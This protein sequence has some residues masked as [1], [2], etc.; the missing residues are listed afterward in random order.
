MNTRS[1]QCFL[2]VDQ[3]IKN[4][5]CL[6]NQPLAEKLGL[7][8][9][10]LNKIHLLQ[11]ATKNNQKS[12]F[13]ILATILNGEFNKSED[14]HLLL[15]S[16]F[17]G[18]LKE[19]LRSGSLSTLDVQDES[20]LK[21][22]FV[23]SV[24][25]AFSGPLYNLKNAQTNLFLQKY[26]LLVESLKRQF[27]TYL[28]LVPT[29]NSLYRV[30][31]ENI[32]LHKTLVFMINNKYYLFKIVHLKNHFQERKPDFENTETVQLAFISDI[33]II[34]N[35]VET[36]RFCRASFEKHDKLTFM[37]FS[38][39][40]FEE[41]K[42]I[43]EYGN[44]GEDGHGFPF[45]DT[46]GI[47]PPT[48]TLFIDTTYLLDRYVV[49]NCVSEKTLV[50][51]KENMIERI[52]DILR[53]ISR[54]NSSHREKFITVDIYLYNFLHSFSNLSPKANTRDQL[55]DLLDFNC[56]NRALLL[57]YR[58]S[59]SL[60]KPILFQSTKF[61]KLIYLNSKTPCGGKSPHA[62]VNL[63]WSQMY[64]ALKKELNKHIHIDIL[65]RN[66]ELFLELVY[67]GG[68]IRGRGVQAETKPGEIQGE[69]LNWLIRVCF[70]L[71]NRKS[72][73][74]IVDILFRNSLISEELYRRLEI[75]FNL[76]KQKAQKIGFSDEFNVAECTSDLV[77]EDIR[78]TIEEIDR[79]MSIYKIFGNEYQDINKLMNQQFVP[80]IL[81]YRSNE[82]AL[83]KISPLKQQ[84]VNF[85]KKNYV[86]YKIVNQHILS[87]ISPFV[88]QSEDNIRRLFNASVPTILLL[89]GIELISGKSSRV[90]TEENGPE[91]RRRDEGLPRGNEEIKA[92]IPPRDGAK[93]QS[94]SNQC[95]PLHESPNT[96]SSMIQRHRT[97]LQ[98]MFNSNWNSE[99]YSL[100]RFS[101]SQTEPDNSNDRTLLT[102]LL[103]CLDNVEKRN[104][105]VIVIAFSN[106]HLSQLDESII[107][108][109]RLDV[110]LPI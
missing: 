17:S 77:D 90:D 28:K 95:S 47:G 7:D 4:G 94:K 110:H 36:E 69:T 42:K 18:L 32:F 84:L 22:D 2:G 71:S 46:D 91:L 54:F 45:P 80:R 87:L 72:A 50:N 51:I 8:E 74:Q 82:H 102:T 106:K 29:K 37:E 19:D 100:K 20:I 83:S 16:G 31:L 58:N 24:E 81:I 63:E 21:E 79:Q 38:V 70:G 101:N 85:I 96:I 1:I 5:I 53:E 52:K 76:A 55:Q 10:D 75:D 48:S 23:S 73:F 43:I 59:N 57:E 66:F 98:N 3:E 34:P 64:A 89:E 68:I 93:F 78:L 99:D 26:K 67:Y 11:L 35:L 65:D 105:N 104:Q 103:L 41:L 60:K 97:E 13:L 6:I 39:A 56:V 88:G 9:A 108:A 109:G 12:I 15:H 62:K 107:R 86:N 40:H 33:L 14:C 25:L 27:F 30:K 44:N 92:P 49:E 61:L